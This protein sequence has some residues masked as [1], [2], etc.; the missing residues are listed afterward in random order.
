MAQWGP[1][2]NLPNT[3]AWFCQEFHN[4]ENV[5][6]VVK[7]FA[8]GNSQIDKDFLEKA[9]KSVLDNFP[10]RKCKVYFLHGYMNNQE[11]HSL[12]VHPKI[13]AM[14][15][16]GHGEGYGL[17]L[18][19]AA[20]SGLPVITHDFGGQK[21]FL[22]APKKGKKGEKLRAHFSRVNYGCN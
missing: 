2:K 14:V 19:E 7:T 4:D 17:P 1:R 9:L 10:D 18:F 16:F 13:K 12:Y 8:K 21:D 5:G 20:Y 15:N 11:L 6:L 3:I 22:Y